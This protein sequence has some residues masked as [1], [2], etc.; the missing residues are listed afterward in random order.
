VTVFKNSIEHAYDIKEIVDF[1]KLNIKWR[2]SQLPYVT[3][4]QGRPR[5]SGYESGGT[6]VNGTPRPLSLQIDGVTQSFLKLD[7][8]V[9]EYPNDFPNA[10]FGAVMEAL[11]R[12]C[13][14]G[15]KLPLEF[16]YQSMTGGV[17]QRFFA[18]KARNTFLEDK[19]WLKAVLLNPIKNRMIEAGTRSGM[20]DLK[21]FGNLSNDMARFRGTWQMGREISVDFGKEVDAS[22][23]LVD[24]GFM[25]S[26]E[27]ITDL[28]GNPDIVRRKVRERAVAIIKDAQAV[29]E[30]TGMPIDQVLPFISKKFPNQAP[31]QGGGAPVMDSA[32]SPDGTQAPRSSAEAV[33][34]DD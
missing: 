7:E 8:G 15:C 26:D 5:G 18:D 20:L 16:V 4:E 11:K 29:A 25:S 3:N 10:Q 9:M 30:E 19:R 1:T 34:V 22:I 12:D 2:S 32:P 31:V 13:S 24:G 21:R 23:K 17:V 27:Y 6:T 14:I 28:G 33:G